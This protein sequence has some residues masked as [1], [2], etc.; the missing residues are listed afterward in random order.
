M[1]DWVFHR[2][3]NP[4]LLETKT[5][6]ESFFSLSDGTKIVLG[7]FGVA[8]IFFGIGYALRPVEEV[9]DDLHDSQ[10]NIKL[11]HIQEKT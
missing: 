8:A 7:L 10:E 5:Q 4:D 1:L 3:N 11:H 2:L 6:K 9:F